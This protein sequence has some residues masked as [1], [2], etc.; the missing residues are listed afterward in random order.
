MQLLGKVQRY[1]QKTGLPPT[2]FGRLS[3]NDPRL[4]GDMING[5]TPRQRMIARIEAYIAAHANQRY[6]PGPKGNRLR[7]RRR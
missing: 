3:V 2:L 1:L 5:R 6:V 7:G 4:V